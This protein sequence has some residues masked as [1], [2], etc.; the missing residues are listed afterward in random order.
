MSATRFACAVWLVAFL[1]AP[2]GAQPKFN[3]GE[4][5]KSVVFVKRLTPGTEPASGSG[6]LVSKDGLVYTNRH[7][8]V[9]D[10]PVAG[11]IVV[12]VPSPKD[13]DELRFFRAEV[14]YA[15]PAKDGR[16]FAVLKIAA[17]SGEPAFP[18]LAINTA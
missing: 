10:A 16:D 5:R 18:A 1:A 3:P 8:A 7:V 15:T 4:L 6:F 13:S 14:V 2:A 12:G 11:S 17:K 9:P